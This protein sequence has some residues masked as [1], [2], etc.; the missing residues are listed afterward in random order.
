MIPLTSRPVTAMNREALTATHTQNIQLLLTQQYSRFS[1]DRKWIQRDTELGNMNRSRQGLNTIR[2]EEKPPCCPRESTSPRHWAQTVNEGKP[3]LHDR[4]TNSKW[5][6]AFC[7]RW[8]SSWYSYFRV[9][10]NQIKTSF[11]FKRQHIQRFMEAK[12][13]ESTRYEINHNGH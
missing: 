11:F 2:Q 13:F 5:K 6:D 4:Y 1:S 7:C 9:A 8:G 12:Y 3:V 10:Y